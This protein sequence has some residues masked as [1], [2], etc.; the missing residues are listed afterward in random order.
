MQPKFW[1]GIRWG[2]G[3]VL[4]VLF[5]GGLVGFWST[6][7]RP[8]WS[9]RTWVS[10]QTSDGGAS[11]RYEVT[12][13]QRRVLHRALNEPGD[14]VDNF[15]GRVVFRLNGK[16]RVLTSFRLWTGT[17]GIDGKGE[18]ETALGSL[19]PAWN[20]GARVFYFPSSEKILVLNA[21]MKKWSLFSFD[22]TYPAVQGWDLRL[23]Q[24]SD[25]AAMI[26]EVERQLAE[27]G[28]SIKLT[29]AASY[30]MMIQNADVLK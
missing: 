30:L 2:V 5:V 26:Q 27:K 15:F 12:G 10:V 3:I 6:G 9:A 19:S 28:H 23:E 21:T 16:D 18:D 17:P 25:E 29:G 13:R 8:Y 1:S 11:L 4:G 14:L 20:K 24:G 22:P 7:Y